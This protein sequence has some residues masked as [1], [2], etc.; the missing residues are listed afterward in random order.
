MILIF[1]SIVILDLL[2]SLVFLVLSSSKVIVEK[3]V[4]TMIMKSRDVL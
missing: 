1:V 3:I 4:S 2:S